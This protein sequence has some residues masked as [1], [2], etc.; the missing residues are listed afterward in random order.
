M[1]GVGAFCGP[2]L[3]LPG[4]SASKFILRGKASGLECLLHGLKNA[5]FLEGNKWLA[6]KM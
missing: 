4:D 3:C 5:P 1:E 6:I 2:S